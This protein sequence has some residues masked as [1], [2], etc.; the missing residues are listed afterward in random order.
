MKHTVSLLS[1]LL[2]SSSALIAQNSAPPSPGGPMILDVQVSDKS[3][4]PVTGLSQQDFTLVDGKQTLGLSYFHEVSA[5]AGKDQN[6]A[7]EVVLVVDAI[8]SK[9]SDI[10]YFRNEVKDYLLRDNGDLSYPTSLVVVTR[11]GTKLQ[12]QPGKDGKAI[13]A[14]FEQFSTGLRADNQRDSAYGAEELLDVGVKTLTQ[15]VQYEAQKP[16]RKLMIWISPGWP[17]V[18]GPDMRLSSKDEKMFFENIVS[19]SNA[20]RAAHTTLY[21][22]DP[23]GI[24]STSRANLDYY[25][26][27]LKPATKP[28]DSEP[29]DLGLQVLALQSGGRVLNAGTGLGDEIAQCVNDARS[30]YVLTFDPTKGGK[31]NDF[32]KLAVNV[33]KPGLTVRTRVGYYSQ[34]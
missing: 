27:F 20:L 2:I 7:L 18:A 13:N 21:D 17:F 24:A 16:G 34:P 10:S 28:S 22:V 30:Y 9:F 33:N 12:P 11:E 5:A 23:G 4:A 3:G 15:L 19:V 32:H 1:A 8:N 26:V 14:M 25:K 31:A 6:P 29:G